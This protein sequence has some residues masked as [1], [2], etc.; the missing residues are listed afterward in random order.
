MA[1]KIVEPKKTMAKRI[2]VN[3]S[4]LPD[5]SRKIPQNNEK[6]SRANPTNE[7]NLRGT[8]EKLVIPSMAKLSSRL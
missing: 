4:K 5:R 2:S 6:V 8:I 3:L 7:A 1:I